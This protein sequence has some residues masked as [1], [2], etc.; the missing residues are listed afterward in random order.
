[1]AREDLTAAAQTAPIKTSLIFGASGAGKT[2]LASTFPAPAVICSKR[3]GGYESIRY[4][5]RSL[6]YE[7]NIPPQVYTVNSMVECLGHLHK[8]ILPQVPGGKVKTI[9]IEL[10]FY[11]DDVFRNLPLDEK[12]GW[13]KYQALE[14]HVQ[15]L[16]IEI[17]KYPALRLCYT[18]LAAAADD[19]KT[20]GGIILPGKAVAK[21]IPAVCN[22]TG[23][24]RAEEVGKNVDRVLHLS[25][26]GSYSPRHRYGTSLPAFVRN[27]TFRLLEDLIAK[28]VQL[29]S[30]GYV[31]KNEKKSG[32]VGSLVSLPALKPLP[33][34]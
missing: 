29:D 30:N 7:P 9:V 14:S 3:E 18:A 32:A 15:W 34:L 17:K 1:M 28:R 33:P 21:K 26:Y 5:D 10:T 11:A 4:M 23:Y 27:P 6:W 25:A 31:I 2:V 19:A 16:D 13:A 22:L 8:D 12:N 20:P 24:L